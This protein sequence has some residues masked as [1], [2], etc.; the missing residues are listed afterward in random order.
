[1]KLNLKV[2]R[3]HVPQPVESL[4]PA[5]RAF[6]TPDLESAC[7]SCGDARGFGSPMTRMMI[8]QPAS[9]QTPEASATC[10]PDDDDQPAGRSSKDGQEEVAGSQGHAASGVHSLNFPSPRSSGALDLEGDGGQMEDGN[11]K[12]SDM[13]AS[14]L[15]GASPPAKPEQKSLPQKRSLVE[16]RSRVAVSGCGQ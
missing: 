5:G 13:S 16:A 15:L 6:C 1:M 10:D 14:T 3:K 8:M 2:R 7:G 9:G 11:D 12:E 4:L